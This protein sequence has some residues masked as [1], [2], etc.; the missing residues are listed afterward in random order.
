[1]KVDGGPLESERFLVT[2]RRGD[3]GYFRFEERSEL[4]PEPIVD[5]LH[6]RLAGV[7]FRGVVSEAVRAELT[8]RFQRSPARRRRGPAAPGEYVGAYHAGKGIDQYLDDAAAVE[9]SLRRILDL[10]G[11][12][13][14]ALRRG[15]AAALAEEGVDFRT[16]RHG[17]REAGLAILRSWRG[18]G[19]FALA[20]H[21]DIGQCC[22]PEQDGFEIQR[23]GDHQVVA[24]NM[25]LANGAGGRL[26]LWNVQPDLASRKRLGVEFWGVPYPVECLDGI[27]LISLDVN[28]GDIYLFNGR[29]VHAVEAGADT[30]LR[31]TL[32]SLL[33]FIDAKTVVSWT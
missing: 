31:L 16:A 11:D 19:A 22:A 17:D 24:L 15:V 2:G 10:P 26:F 7:I 29:H 25:C 21:D 33:G 9:A 1:M 28:P 27:E 6:G 14:T 8:A 3:P 30:S 13:L 23:V 12:P 4:R 20:P 5:I 18:Q 32:S